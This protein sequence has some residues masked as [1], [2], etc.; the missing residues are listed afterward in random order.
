[1][2]P[3]PFLLLGMFLIFLE[4]LAPGIVMGTLGLICLFASVILFAAQVASPLAVVFYV[5]GIIVFLVLLINGTLRYI[6]STGP[7]ESLFLKKDQEGYRVE[8][9]APSLI[10]REGV[11]ATDLRPSGSV[12]IGDEPLQAL[13]QGNFIAKGS[14]VSVIGIDGAAVIVKSLT[15]DSP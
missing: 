14:R 7:K 2:S 1:M 8:S 5:L 15:E 9:Y 3:Y 13:S 12:T 11:A 6:R 10:G 4:F